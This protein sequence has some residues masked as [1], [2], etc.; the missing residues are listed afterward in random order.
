MLT[1]A[2]ILSDY[3]KIRDAC[4]PDD[5]SCHFL[6]QLVEFAWNGEGTVQGDSGFRSALV[7]VQKPISEV[8]GRCAS[9]EEPKVLQNT[10]KLNNKTIL[11]RSEAI[12]ALMNVLQ[13]MVGTHQ[14]H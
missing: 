4:A 11:S 2:L 1:L 9:L 6:S 13:V 8:A 5:K 12:I 10:S 7:E 3:N 14:P